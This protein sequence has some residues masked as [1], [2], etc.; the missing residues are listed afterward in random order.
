MTTSPITPTS[1]KP[2]NSFQREPSILFYLCILSPI[3]PTSRM[4]LLIKNIALGAL[5][6]PILAFADQGGAYCGNGVQ[7]PHD[8]CVDAINKIDGSQWYRSASFMAG[9]CTVA[10]N[11]IGAGDNAPSIGGN[12]FRAEAWGIMNSC[13]TDGWCT[14]SGLNVREIQTFFPKPKSKAVH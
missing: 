11:M 12:D 14:D 7:P 10:V 1:F 3:F 13:G 8:D 5:L 2:S 9:S 6:F 4:S